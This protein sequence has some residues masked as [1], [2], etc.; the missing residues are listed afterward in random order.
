[1]KARI[2]GQKFGKSQR[3]LT[4]GGLSPN[5]S[6]KIGGKPFLENWAFSGLIGTFPGCIGAFSGPIGT[7]SSAPLSHGKAD[8]GPKRPVF[9]PMGAF[10]AKPP[11][12]KPPFGFPKKEGPNEALL[13][14][15]S[16]RAHCRGRP[17]HDHDH[18][19]VHLAMPHFLIFGAPDDAPERTRCPF[20]S[21]THWNTEKPQRFFI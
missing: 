2:S 10:R 4:N 15:P 17:N 12:A 7:N 3:G 13:N 1:M 14:G 20:Y 21:I 16:K 18:F 5:F 11:F 19:G 8:I 6:E 9:G